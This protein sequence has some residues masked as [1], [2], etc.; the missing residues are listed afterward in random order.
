MGRLR[1]SHKTLGFV[2]AITAAVGWG[3]FGTFSTFLM[4]FGLSQG[5]VSL[6]SPLFLLVFFGIFVLVKNGWR[7]LIP[8]PRLIPV[9]LLMGVVEAFFSYSTVSAYRY[10]PFAIVSTII[11]CN[12]FLLLIF[13]RIIF[14]TAITVQKLIAVVLAVLGIAMVVDAFGNHP[15]NS[16]LGFGWAALAMLCWAVLVICEKYLLEKGVNGNAVP[17]WEGLLGSI[18]IS[19]TVCS[20]STAATE[21]VQAFSAH[22]LIV[23]LPLLGFGMLTTVFCFWMYIHALNRLEPTYVQIA[24]TLDP[25]TTCLL[26]LIVFGQKLAPIQIAG[27]VVVLAVVIGVQLLDR[28]HENPA[29]EKQ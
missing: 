25:T 24:F 23:L 15:G 6:I 14:K 5:T 21:L 13:S 8:K 12:L 2:M 1:S 20:P 28:Q 16:L 26:G 4:D 11:Y 10:L 29:I 9:V 27:M 22:G 18:I 3:T 19:F 7:V 17:A